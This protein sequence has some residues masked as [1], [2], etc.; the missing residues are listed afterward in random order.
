[1]RCLFERILG[2]KP[3]VT[4]IH[5]ITLAAIPYTCRWIGEM[6]DVL[7]RQLIP[8]MTNPCEIENGQLHSLT[9]SHIM[10]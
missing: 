10:S 4:P 9:T 3:V 1:M 5:V 2:N 7:Y 6:T 8:E